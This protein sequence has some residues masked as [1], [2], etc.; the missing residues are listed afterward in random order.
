MI[1]IMIVIMIILLLFI[2]F[3]APPAQYCVLSI[4]SRSAQCA[5][6]PPRKT[7]ILRRSGLFSIGKMPCDKKI[8]DLRTPTSQNRHTHASCNAVERKPLRGVDRPHPAQL[9]CHHFD[10]RCQR[11]TLHL[12]VDDASL[13]V[14]GPRVPP[15]HHLSNGSG[16]STNTSIAIK[17]T[18]ATT[19]SKTRRA[20]H[21]QQV[22]NC[23]LRP[24]AI[25]TTTRLDNARLCLAFSITHHPIFNAM[26]ARCT[27]LRNRTKAP[28]PTGVPWLHSCAVYLSRTT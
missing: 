11:T 14:L 19:L 17:C 12:S 24:P 9:Q 7:Y 25:A 16:N 21:W 15:Y 2:I 28:M 13:H 5:F 22:A 23:A 4:A 20:G 6:E 1:M 27:L 26:G 8:L 3:V 10:G 18:P